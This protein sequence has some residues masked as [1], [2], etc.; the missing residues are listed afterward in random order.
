MWQGTIRARRSSNCVPGLLLCRKCV[1][2][3]GAVFCGKKRRCSVRDNAIKRYIP[4][5]WRNFLDFLAVKGNAEKFGSPPGFAMAQKRKTTIEV[6]GA[7]PDAMVLFIESD[8]RGNNEVEIFR[9]NDSAA[10]RFPDAKPVLFEFGI[11]GYFA[12]QH[13]G[14]AAHNRN[15]NALVRAPGALNDFARVD[16][17]MHRQVRAEQFARGIFARLDDASAD[18]ARCLAALVGRHRTARR[19]CLRTLFLHPGGHVA[20]PGKRRRFP[21]VPSPSRRSRTG[22]TGGVSRGRNRLTV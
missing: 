15:E 22:A 9:L 8:R 3:H 21:P 4:S 7:H 10:R 5:V 18:D 1:Y 6:T 12:E 20:S 14:A 19:K 2:R 16:F 11:R 13:L 17:V